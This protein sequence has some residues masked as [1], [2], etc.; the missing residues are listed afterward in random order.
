MKRALMLT[1]AVAA[2]ALVSLAG[3]SSALAVKTV[4]C[5]SSGSNCASGNEYASGTS[6][7]AS[8]TNMKIAAGSLGSLTCSEASLE[9]KTKAASGEP[10]PAEVTAWTFSG[11]VR[12]KLLGGTES[13]T[14]TTEHLPYSASI[15]YAESYN[16]GTMSFTGSGGEAGWYILCGSGANINC[17]FGFSSASV[18]GGNPAH[19]SFNQSLKKSGSN[20]PSE[21]N[22]TA[23][24]TVNSP[25]PAYVSPVELATGK[26]TV[27]CDRIESPCLGN[28]FPSATKFE[29]GLV[30][31]TTVSMELPPYGSPFTCS[32]SSFSGETTATSGEE[33]LPA[34]IGSFSMSGCGRSGVGGFEACTMTTEGLPY[35]T[36]FGWYSKEL[37]GVKPR[38]TVK[39]LKLHMD[40]GT[41]GLHCTFS[42]VE[43]FFEMTNGSPAV[44]KLN[45][46]LARTGAFCPTESVFKAEYQI[47]SPKPG[48]LDYNP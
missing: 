9:G 33:S 38:V 24:Y 42:T 39:G 11:C 43:A 21:A 41:N 8:S 1:V 40:C 20:C 5:K 10:L 3:A 29:A 26:G 12:H 47:N 14:T 45:Q 15:A 18:E 25:Q 28:V 13:C 7:K 34:S 30:P 17:T 44:L 2:L 16:N 23:T 48:Y 4:L 35:S 46:S 37:V 27:L 36:A 6:L 22:L 32:G 19:L 31:G